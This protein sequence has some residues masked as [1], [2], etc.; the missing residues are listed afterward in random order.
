[1]ANTQSNELSEMT[2]L[3]SLSRR[4]RQIM[5][6]LYTAEEATV[7]EIQPQLPDPPTE[8]AIRRLLSILEE[9]GHVKRRKVGRGHGYR[10]SVTKKRAAK[11]ALKGVLNTF[12]GGDVEQALA[13]YLS[14]KNSPFTDEQFDRMMKLIEEARKKQKE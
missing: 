8:M 4:E 5:E 12:F 14:D 2:D 6:I 3:S 10:P 9:K 11:T 7:I 13:M 1:V